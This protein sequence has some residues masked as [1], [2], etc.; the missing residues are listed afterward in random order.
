MEW[1]SVENK[2]PDVQAGVFIV[3]LDDS[4]EHRA[5]FYEDAIAWIAF[6]GQKTSHWWGARYPYSRLDGVTHWKE[7]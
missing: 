4:T 7:L 5:F 2:L 3:K 6:Y 1:I